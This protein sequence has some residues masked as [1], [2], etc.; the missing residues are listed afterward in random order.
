LLEDSAAEEVV[1]SVE[2][3]AAGF[4]AV[5]VVASVA[6]VASTGAEG[7]RVEVECT[8]AAGVFPVADFI[9]NPR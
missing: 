3:A 8:R 4:T 7:S 6:V 2:E 9:P 1:G 5:E